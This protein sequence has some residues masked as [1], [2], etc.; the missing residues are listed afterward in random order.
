MNTYKLLKRRGEQEAYG[1]ALLREDGSSLSFLFDPAN[2]D[3]QQYLAW[4]AEG[5]T[6]LPADPLPP[7]VYI[8]TPWQIRKA[9]NNLSLRQAV[10]DAVAASNDQTLKDGWEFATH[11]SSSDPFVISMGAS[12]GKNE[13]E[14]AELIQ[15]ASTL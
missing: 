2:T 6:P 15:Y 1:A 8:C 5:N 11:F 10:E 13:Q 12:L 4:L 9:L 7:P 14:T 3:Y